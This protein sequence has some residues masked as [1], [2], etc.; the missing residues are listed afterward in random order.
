[1]AAN[2]G[3]DMRVD[4]ATVAIAGAALLLGT[5][6]N[7]Q[8]KPTF[9]DFEREV[10]MAALRAEGMITGTAPCM[11]EVEGV[12]PTRYK[13]GQ[14]RAIPGCTF[15]EL[16]RWPPGEGPEM[17]VIPAGR[18]R[19]GCVSNDGDCPDR[20][21]P[22]RE[23]TISA[24]FALSV[25]E[26]TFEDYDRFTDPPRGLHIAR[27][28]AAD[29]GWGRGTRPVINV[30]W[31]EAW[32]YTRWLSRKTEAEYRLPTEA[33]WEYAAR[34]GTSTKYAWGDEI[35]VNR[36]NCDSSFCGDQWAHTAPVGSF[37]PNRFGVRGMHGNVWEWVLDCW[38]GNYAGAPKDGRA[39]RGDYALRVRRGG[40]WDDIPTVV[41]AAQRS[42]A[43]TYTRDNT[44]GFRVVRT[45]GSPTSKEQRP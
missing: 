21:K 18:F 19:M 27:R 28:K 32:E 33:E 36:A 8:E 23:V 11:G 2:Q 44:T 6:G 17:V 30:S 20:E 10:V 9:A 13:G 29:E 22:V 35:G 16:F 5:A 43:T 26:V 37:T 31:D 1:M 15:R 40:S 4:S 25:H 42:M 3:D 12:I 7:T 38:N 39:R 24:P 14:P 41:R 34:A 45:L